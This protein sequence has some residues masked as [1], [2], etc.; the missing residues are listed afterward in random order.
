MKTIKTKGKVAVVEHGGERRIVPIEEKDNLAAFAVGMPWGIPWEA[1]ELS[2]SS[3]D[4]AERLRQR[5]IWTVED[6]KN[7]TRGAMAALQAAY[8]V[9]V[10]KLFQFAAKYE[11]VT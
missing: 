4:L 8:G 2:A 3:E 10:S 11:E 6:L 9:D 7:D 1:V 5:G